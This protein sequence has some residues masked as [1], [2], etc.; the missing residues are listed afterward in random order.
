[1]ITYLYG[2]IFDSSI[3]TLVNPVNLEGRMGKGLA[4]KFRNL[5]PA[6]Y[7]D[8]QLDCANGDIAIGKLT[9]Y[10]SGDYKVINFPTKDRYSEPS[11]YKYIE[12]GLINFL[13]MYQ[14]WNITGVA[15]PKLGCGLGGLE[16]ENVKIMMEGFLSN[17][18][19]P[20]EVWL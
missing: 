9:V 16:W 5:Y 1:M 2:D 12:Y 14:E 7:R 8:Y 11:R 17:L 4:V 6:M 18:D 15:F 19:I 10:T 3:Q 20:V 13:E